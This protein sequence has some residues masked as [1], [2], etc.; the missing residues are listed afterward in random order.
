MVENLP[1]MQETQVRSLDL[2][3]PE[4]E[5]VSPAPLALAGG[6]FT[7]STTWETL[8]LPETSPFSF[9]YLWLFHP[10]ILSRWSLAELESSI[11]VKIYGHFIMHL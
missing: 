7:T 1:A 10:F 4:I 11:Q 3:D 2:L 6:F 8:T 5:P 9:T